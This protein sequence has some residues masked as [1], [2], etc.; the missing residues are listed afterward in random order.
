MGGEE[1]IE[2]L[3]QLFRRYVVFQSDAQV[4]ALSL[5]VIHTHAFAAAEATPYPSI[6]SPEKRSGKTRLLEVLEL[7]VARGWLVAGVTEAVLFR[8]IAQQQ[9]TLL[10]DEVDATFGT[11]Q[12]KTEPTRA[13]L[14]AG[15]R[16]GGAVSRCV[17]PNH[18]VEDFGVFSP[19]CL[20]GI[21]D[22]RLPETIRDRTIPIHLHRKR[23][24][25][26][27]ER[28]RFRRGNDEAKEI[29]AAIEEWVEANLAELIPLEPELPEELN[30]RAA[31][32]WEPLLAIAEL[33]GGEITEQARRAAIEL[34]GEDD[35]EDASFG[36]QLLAD[37]KEWWD[38]D[39]DG[40][41][42]LTSDEICSHLRSLLDRPWG[43]WG[44]GR[45]SPGLTQRDLARILRPYGIK[46]KTIRL[47][48]GITKKG[49]MREQF[50]D[51]WDRYVPDELT[52]TSEE[53]E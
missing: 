53:G 31:E 27:I 49:Y 46:P 40:A 33:I 23:P 16:R 3:G 47:P 6:D 22:G 21:N 4:L 2:Q 5:W 25:E 50:V 28:F 34:S 48:A 9:P 29:V 17:P 10:L 39:Q 11:Y 24:G 41:S 15:A 26:K 14:N 18:D 45:P 35:L 1:I 12:E 19:K 51:V 36:T 8:K 30:D 32:G 7:V 43:N 20:A 42:N 38:R 37:L 52:G 13:V 44:K